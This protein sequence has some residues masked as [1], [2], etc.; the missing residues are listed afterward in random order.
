MI[1]IDVINDGPGW[2]ALATYQYCYCIDIKERFYDFKMCNGALT[3][4]KPLGKDVKVSIVY[5][6]VK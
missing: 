5:E 4:Q 3:F 6:Y 1:A 2:Y